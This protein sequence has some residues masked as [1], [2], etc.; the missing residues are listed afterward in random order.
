MSSSN[1]VQSNL[2]REG[3]GPGN[4]QKGEYGDRLFRKIGGGVVH[5]RVPVKFSKSMQ[6]RSEKGPSRKASIIGG[7][8]AF[9]KRNESQRGRGEKGG[10]EG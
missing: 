6:G 9:E 10:R 4:R 7:E 1:V 2:S 3:S 5:Q 8:G